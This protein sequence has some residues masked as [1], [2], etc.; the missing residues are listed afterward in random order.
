V[1]V[2]QRVTSDSPF[3]RH[4]PPRDPCH[5]LLVDEILCGL[6]KAAQLL[7]VVAKKRLREGTSQTKMAGWWVSIY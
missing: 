3:S 2:Y 7:G 6:V 5:L 4:R 1:T